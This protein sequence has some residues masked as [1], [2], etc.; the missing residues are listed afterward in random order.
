MHR[1]Q[2]D[3]VAA[4]VLGCHRGLRVELGT[5]VD[6]PEKAAQVPVAFGLEIGGDRGDPPNVGEPRSAWIPDQVREV[7]ALNAIASLIHTDPARADEAG[8]RLSNYFRAKRGKPP[9]A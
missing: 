1:H 4:F 2:P 8:R 5:C 7:N 3:D 6:P 9:L